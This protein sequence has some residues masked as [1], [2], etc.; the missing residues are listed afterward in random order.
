MVVMESEREVTSASATASAHQPP[1]SNWYVDH[2][3][4]AEEYLKASNN[5]YFSQ[6]SYH[7]M[8]HPHHGKKIGLFLITLSIIQV[9]IV[10][11]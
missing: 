9:L 11:I 6:M 1:T 7:G 2:S 5:S 4:Q 10:K 8:T 3:L